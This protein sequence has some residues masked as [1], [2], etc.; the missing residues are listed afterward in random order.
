MAKK[1]VKPGGRAFGSQSFKRLT[2][3]QDK[4]RKYNE[5]VTG[6]YAGMTPTRRE[7]ARVADMEA[8]DRRRRAKR[9]GR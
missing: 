3:L 1:K 8:K 7:E 9:R 6:K 4:Q 2:N 5:L